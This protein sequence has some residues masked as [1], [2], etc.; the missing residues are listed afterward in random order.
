MNDRIC[1]KLE[2]TA[3]VWKNS[4]TDLLCADFCLCILFVKKKKQNTTELFHYFS[5]YFLQFNYSEY[6]FFFIIWISI[7]TVFTLKYYRPDCAEIW[8][9]RLYRCTE[10]KDSEYAVMWSWIRSWRNV[11]KMCFQC[12]LYIMNQC[13]KQLVFLLEIKNKKSNSLLWGNIKMERGNSV[14]GDNNVFVVVVFLML[15]LL[16]W[17]AEVVKSLV[18]LI[19]CIRRYIKMYLKILQWPLE[20][21][22]TC[23]NNH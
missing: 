15:H 14:N 17:S 20:C 9:E 1:L 2:K 13:W 6:S 10:N 5:K 12:W 19:S 3:G 23:T 7:Y 16:F 22:Y 21:C 4:E 11:E 18:S 8:S